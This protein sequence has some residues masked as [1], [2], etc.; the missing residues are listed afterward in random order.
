MTVRTWTRST[1]Q[2]PADQSSLQQQCR[3]FLM[4]LKTSL[5]SA[6]WTVSQSCDSTQVQSSDTWNALANLVN[7]ASGVHS[8]IVLKSPAGLVAGADGSYTGDQSRLWLSIDLNS[9]NAYLA[10]ILVHRVA[11][12]GGTTSACPTSASQAGY[13][14]QQFN[15]STLAAT[16]K[17][18][19]MTT[20]KGEFIALFG[21]SGAN[22][23]PFGMGIFPVT[24]VRK[25]AS[26]LD[27]PYAVGLHCGYLNSAKGCFDPSNAGYLFSD[28]FGIKSWSADGTTANLIGHAIGTAAGNQ[29]IGAFFPSDGDSSTHLHPSSP[30][31]I[32]NNTS[33][34]TFV[35]G[36]LADIEVT[37]APTA[38]ATADDPTSPTSQLVGGLWL[39]MSAA[40]LIF[41]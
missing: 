41:M 4:F 16:A 22:I 38:Q 13:S 17:F 9:A 34:K 35:I 20:D 30:V 26:N 1:N 37:G 12:T 21:H 10:A 5:V 29:F 33:G 24:G 36:T 15:R 6:G 11:P 27:Y 31:W 14:A 3:S 32:L 7:A 40:D 25:L 19:F 8:W 23:I 2:N 39:P 18:H 28:G